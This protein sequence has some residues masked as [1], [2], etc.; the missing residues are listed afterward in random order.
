MQPNAEQSL[1]RKW[2][3]DSNY[4]Q[5]QEG[6]IDSAHIAFLHGGRP[7]GVP[8]RQS[9]NQFVVNTDYLQ[10]L[11]TTIASGDLPDFL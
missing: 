10:K 5:G 4:S 8:A 1:T 6:Q 3:Q 7:P 9:R 2:L 11:S